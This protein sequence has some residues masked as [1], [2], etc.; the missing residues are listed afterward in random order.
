MRYKKIKIR[1]R[2]LVSLLRGVSFGFLTKSNSEIVEFS[3]RN[4]VL[5]N[6]NFILGELIIRES[7]V[8]LYFSGKNELYK[9]GRIFTVIH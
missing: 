2:Y 7:G 6:T 3:L 1:L 5:R 9:N 8:D 4:K